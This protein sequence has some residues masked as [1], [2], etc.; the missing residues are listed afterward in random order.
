MSDSFKSRLVGSLLIG[1]GILFIVMNWSS[2]HSAY[3]SFEIKSTVIGPVLA[4]LG[5]W[6]IITV[7][8][9]PVYHMDR[10]GW[11]SMIVGFALGFA[12]WYFLDHL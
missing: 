6:A 10:G 1:I 3:L 7:P 12:Y 4:A 9:I 11:I 5:I 8:E 2:A